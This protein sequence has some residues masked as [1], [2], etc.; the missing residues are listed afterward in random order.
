MVVVK[1]RTHLYRG[2]VG[3]WGASRAGTDLECEPCRIS[4]SRPRHVICPDV[5][6]DLL[7]IRDRLKAAGVVLISVH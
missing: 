7:T 2:Q 6:E 1:R 4:S 5:F 3:A